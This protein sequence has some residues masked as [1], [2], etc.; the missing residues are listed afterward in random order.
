MS[1]STRLKEAVRQEISFDRLD[2]QA[3]AEHA[4]DLIKDLLAI[5]PTLIED[6]APGMMLLR[7][8]MTAK[9]RGALAI[10]AMNAAKRAYHEEMLR[11]LTPVVLNI[12]R[13]KTDANGHEIAIALNETAYGPSKSRKTWTYADVRRLLKE[14]NLELEPPAP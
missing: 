1:P 13:L 11:A 6:L 7:R 9:E 5:D 8:P 2:M 3:G 10:P 4:V 14:L 12:R